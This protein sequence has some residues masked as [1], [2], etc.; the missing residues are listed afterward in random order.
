LRAYGAGTTAPP[1]NKLPAYAG[2]YGDGLMGPAGGLSL[3]S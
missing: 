3:H 1:L 2:V